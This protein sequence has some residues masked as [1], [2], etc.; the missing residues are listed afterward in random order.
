L[1]CIRAI[2]AGSLRA[3]AVAVVCAAAINAAAADRACAPDAEESAVRIKGW[4]QLQD[5]FHKYGL[6]A[7]DDGELAEAYSERVDK[8]LTRQWKDI[9]TLAFLVKSDPE[10][11]Q[12]VL[13][14]VDARWE[15]G[16]A[17]RIASAARKHCPKSATALC[18]KIIKAIDT[19][20]W[21]P[22]LESTQDK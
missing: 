13:R 10:F 15:E 16:D 9:S 2:V 8:L 17:E 3:A 22:M 4:I 14:H 18:A 21:G 1:R 11:M 20:D 7:C 6:G 19:M 12:F 5:H